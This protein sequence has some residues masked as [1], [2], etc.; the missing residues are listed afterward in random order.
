MNVQHRVSIVVIVSRPNFLHGMLESII[1]Q[2]S[3]RWELIL[4]V[5]GVT[6]KEK[7]YVANL[8]EN[9]A[10]KKMRVYFHDKVEVG[11]ARKKLYKLARYPYIL[12]VDDDD[13]IVPNAV[14]KVLRCFKKYPDASIV[15]GGKVSV[16]HDM[17]YDYDSVVKLSKTTCHP[18]PRI[19]IFGMTAD[20]GNVNQLYC[21]N[22][23]LLDAVGELKTYRDFYHVGEEVDLFLKLEE[24]GP[25]VWIDKMLYLKRKHDKNVLKRFSSAGLIKLLRRYA[26]DGIKRRKLK[27]KIAST[28]FPECLDVDGIKRPKLE[29]LYKQIH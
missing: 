16:A 19:K 7:Y 26:Q 29:F 6:A 1:H 5:N 4:L 27:I 22:K 23:K 13:M 21:I 15:R 12:P 24:K 20:V 10:S 18:C 28:R 3:S 2:S 9:Y 11:I 8:L 14:E 25:I 17:E